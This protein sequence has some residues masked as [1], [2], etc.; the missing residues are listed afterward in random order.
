MPEPLLRLR[1]TGDAL[2]QAASSVQLSPRIDEATATTAGTGTALTLRPGI[3]PA[4]DLT[5]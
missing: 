2:S 4:K 3:H 1:Q 5:A